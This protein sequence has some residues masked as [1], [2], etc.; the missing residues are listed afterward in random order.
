MISQGGTWHDV[1]APDLPNNKLT[2][3][4]ILIRGAFG[5]CVKN[6]IYA[7]GSLLVQKH[8]EETLVNEK[9]TFVV[10]SLVL[11][12]LPSILLFFRKSLDDSEEYLH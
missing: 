6:C 4:K 12:L 1:P 11:A 7:V 10:Q 2:P 9:G 3:L 8:K 5:F